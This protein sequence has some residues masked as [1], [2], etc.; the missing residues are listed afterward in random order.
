MDGIVLASP[1]YYTIRYSLNPLTNKKSVVDPKRAREQWERLKNRYEAHGIP[2]HVV[3]AA[4]ADPIGKFPD[5]VYVSNS[6]LILRG[7]PAPV[8]ILSR[9][10]HPERQGEEARIGA[11]LKHKL[12][13]KVLEL[14]DREG[15]Y[16]EGQG[17][18]RWSHDGRHL[19]FAYGAGRSTNAGIEAV[20]KV[21]LEEAAANGWLPPKFHRLHIVEKKTY[22]MDL[23]FLPL[24]NGKILFHAGSF[25]AASRAQV[26]HAF[27]KEN[28]VDVPLKYLYACNSVWLP[29]GTLIIPKL[30]N[31]PHGAC[32]GW[33]HKATGMRVEEA[34]VSEFQLA[35]GS[36]SCMTLPI[37]VRP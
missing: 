11:Y 13:F 10:A 19:W 34:S 12:G 30:D 25:D 37:W 27:G 35:G 9:Y 36:V 2:V 22:H 3:D 5:F 32:R 29:D 6:A 31:G 33:M 26:K 23:C 14:P 7:W 1:E 17:D 18:C 21:I 8:A 4:V 15:L 16:F 24:P 20:E 28:M